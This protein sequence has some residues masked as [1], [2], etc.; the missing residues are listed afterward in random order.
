MAAKGRILDI[1]F[2]ARASLPR[3]IG[4]R[5]VRRLNAANVVAYV[6]LSEVYTFTNFFPETN[7]TYRLLTVEEY[8]RVKALDMNSG[9]SAYQEIVAW[10]QLE[11]S[12]VLKQGIIDARL[13]SQLRDKLLAFQAAFGGLYNNADQPISFFYVHF[14]CLLSALYLPL[15][16][17]SS[18]FGA[19]VGQDIF[20]TADVV[21]GLIVLLQSI[22]VVGLRQLGQNMSDPFGSDLEDLSVMH[23]VDSTWRMS[24][25]I[26]E[27]RELQP[28]SKTEEEIVRERVSIGTAWEHGQKKSKKARGSSI[29]VTQSIVEQEE[30]DA[31]VETSYHI[32]T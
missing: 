32:L 9:P 29:S 12:S 5:I 13:A 26:M 2:M 30:E 15:F 10:C 4:L 8:V 20:W 24:N 23:Y 28:G 3:E 25:R 21:N 19:G 22:F 7:D 11:V 1:A 31:G 16:A 18:A 27:A 6:G 17:I 14:I